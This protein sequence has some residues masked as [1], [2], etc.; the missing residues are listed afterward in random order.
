MSRTLFLSLFLPLLAAECV[1]KFVL[2]S[3]PWTNT[4]A[5]LGLGV[6]A[7]RLYLGPQASE[8]EQCPPDCL[9][10][11]ESLSEGGDQ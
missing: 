5:L 4:F 2:H 11:A 8:A 9:K 1:A 3:Q 6:L 7:V 10:C